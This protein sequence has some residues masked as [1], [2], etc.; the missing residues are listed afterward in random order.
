MLTTEIKKSIIQFELD[1]KNFIPIEMMIN[2]EGPF[3]FLLDTGAQ[4]NIIST[5]LATKLGIVGK[6]ILHS[7]SGVG[8][9]TSQVRPAILE[10]IQIA[11]LEN[12]IQ[13]EAR[14]GIVDIMV[15]EENFSNI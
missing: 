7:S 12:T 3:W 13:K 10:S 14:V 4:F 1:T 9:A 15:F 11:G 6:D 2:G 5:K 8:R